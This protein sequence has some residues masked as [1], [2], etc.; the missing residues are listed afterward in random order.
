MQRGGPTTS[1]NRIFGGGGSDGPE[2]EKPSVHELF[3]AA[4]RNELNLQQLAQAL[5]ALHGIH[6]T[7]AAARLLLSVDAAS[8]RLTFAQ[9]Q[10]SLLLEEGG[11]VGE[12]GRPNV[13]EDQAKAIIEDN[14]GEP[15][16]PRVGD[17]AKHSTD[18]SADPFVK[19]RRHMEQSQ[20]RGPFSANPVMDTNRPSM[21]NPLVASRAPR[22]EAP[23][24]SWDGA[25]EMANTATRMFVG[26]ELDGAGYEKFLRRFGVQMTPE[27][28][29]HRLVLRQ[30]RTGDC[31]F[32]DIMRALQRELART[33]AA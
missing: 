30:Q 23:E 31:K 11:D 17:P 27:C 14:L 25:R 28:E 22:E 18:I 19:Q 13:F 10:K 32:V 16:A 21:G 7:P 5:S 29:L 26:G 1:H 20:A 24:D 4:M 2:D 33:A 15:V 6:L 8:G 12:A 3:S 9:F